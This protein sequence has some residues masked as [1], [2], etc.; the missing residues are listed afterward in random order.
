MYLR[1]KQLRES[2]NMSSKE[3]STS[4]G[5]DSSQYS[6][7]EQG[8]LMPTI[9]HL[10]EICTIYGTSMDYLC[11]GKIQETVN[12]TNNDLINIQKELI[13][14]QKEKIASLEAQNIELKA[15]LEGDNKSTDRRAAG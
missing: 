14:M 12:S 10:M 15:Q 11:F 2:K 5:V 13:A 8:K 6:K 9:A 1:I 3:F 4:I 7:I